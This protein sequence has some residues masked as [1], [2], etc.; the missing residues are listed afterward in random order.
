[1][2]EK[3]IPCTII[4]KSGA[5][6]H[7]SLLDLKVEW[8]RSQSEVTKITWRTGGSGDYPTQPI[9]AGIANIEAVYQ[10]HV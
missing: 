3:L 7:L 6:V 8:D 4:Y 5:K 10:G 2:A 9:M 1:M